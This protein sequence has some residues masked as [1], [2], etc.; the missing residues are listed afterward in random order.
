[1]RFAA[2]R[3][4]VLRTCIE[5]ANQGY[6]AGTGG[7]VALRVDGEHFAVTPSAID[8]Y[9]MT[10]ADICIVRLSDHGQVEGRAKASVEAGL[11][12]AIF[13]SR[14][15]CLASVHTHQPV[16]SAYT[17]LGRPLDV[18][19]DPRRRLL[20]SRVPC[21][22]YAPS[23]TPRL[24]RR[25]ARAFSPEAHACMMRNHGAVC[26]GGAL[27]EATSRVAALEAECASFF[28][29]R[30]AAR[31]PQDEPRVQALVADT[32]RAALAADPTS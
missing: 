16:A 19:E 2:G 8:Y 32:L 18:R 10:D 12:A 4:Q 28:L 27:A 17:L 30:A 26:V 13:R 23:G 6:L 1:M 7:N 29:E 14:P 25:V 21:V 31:S 5:L 3:A 22:G 20:G 24:A 11:H 9:A 15:D